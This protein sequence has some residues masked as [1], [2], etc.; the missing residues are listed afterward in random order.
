MLLAGVGGAP[1][2]A[3]VAPALTA[4]CGSGITAAQL[5]LVG[6]DVG[7]DVALY[8]GSWSHWVQDPEHPI[9]TGG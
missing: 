8:P 7:V 6:H 5:V 2:L 9:A 3:G 1:G 4:Y